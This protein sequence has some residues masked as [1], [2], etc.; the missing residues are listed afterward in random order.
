MAVF[1]AALRKS[2]V[3]RVNRNVWEAIMQY[4]MYCQIPRIYVEIKDEFG[5]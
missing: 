4:D 1:L 5:M 2:L 3:L